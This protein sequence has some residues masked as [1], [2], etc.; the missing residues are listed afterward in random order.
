MSRW[1]KLLTVM[2]IVITATTN[3]NAECPLQI[4]VLIHRSKNAGNMQTVTT[5]IC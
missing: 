1:V 3:H 4:S 5:A 2:P